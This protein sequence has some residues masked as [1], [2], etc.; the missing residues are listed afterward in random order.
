M[1]FLEFCGFFLEMSMS[2]DNYCIF[3]QVQ[4]RVAA[5]DGFWARSDGNQIVYLPSGSISQTQLPHVS[6]QAV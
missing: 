5:V 6:M 4:S 1:K 2:L 3:T